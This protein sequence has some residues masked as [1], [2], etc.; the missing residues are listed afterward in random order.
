MGAIVPTLKTVQSISK[1][2]AAQKGQL[3]AAPLMQEMYA[4]TCVPYH[5]TPV[6][7]GCD[8][9]LG[10]FHHWLLRSHKI[11]KIQHHV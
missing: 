10:I 9:L 6:R 7:L 3:K 4:F 11:Q 2:K 1:N 8:D 5:H